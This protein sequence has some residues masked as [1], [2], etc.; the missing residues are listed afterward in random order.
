MQPL[1]A[2]VG[3]ESS[4]KT[5]LAADLASHFRTVWLPEY[6]R[7]RLR[8]SD[9]S[10]SDL[11]QISREQHARETDFIKASAAL[12]IFDTD[13]LVIRIWWLE[14]YRRYPHEIS[15]LF[16]S[17]ANRLYLLTTPEMSWE[18]DVL[19]ESPTDRDRLFRIYE[20]TLQ[21]LGMT[22]HVI[23]GTREQRVELAALA[24]TKYC[25]KLE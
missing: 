19:R 18:P 7:L 17:Q 23:G 3:P 20:G 21:E 15:E 25:E 10:D 9:Y 1:V 13:G 6:A 14:K 8:N 4:G 5:T 16:D 2:I 24:I 22:Y 11:F 12:S